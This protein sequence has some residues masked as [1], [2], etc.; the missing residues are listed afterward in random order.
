[1]FPIEEFDL[2][3]DIEGAELELVKDDAG[4]LSRC[5][6]AIIEMHPDVFAGTRQLRGRLCR[7]ARR[8]PDW[9]SSTATRM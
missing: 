4:A 7:I 6:L 2:V 3:C 9:T 1:M 5:H 8:L